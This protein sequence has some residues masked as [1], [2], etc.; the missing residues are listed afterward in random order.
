LD[1]TPETA[2]EVELET[3]DLKATAAENLQEIQPPASGSG[4]QVDDLNGSPD[5]E[6]QIQSGSESLFE[7]ASTDLSR[8]DDE[9]ER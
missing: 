5:D 8:H 2:A 4:I 1:A 9:S 6:L 3:A 7:A